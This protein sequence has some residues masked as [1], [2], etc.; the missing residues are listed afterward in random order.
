MVVLE[1]SVSDA[2]NLFFHDEMPTKYQVVK[3][4]YSIFVEVDKKSYLPAVSMNALS[5]DGANYVLKERKSK[6]AQSCVSFDQFTKKTENHIEFFWYP[7][8]EEDTS[9]AVI[10]Y[11][12]VLRPDETL[13]GSEELKFNLIS[14]GIYY[15][16]DAL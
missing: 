6:T 16:I 11:F 13:V 2:S 10:I 15:V 7:C 12:D 8:G 14:N 9:E 3:N 1:R 5:D 4:E